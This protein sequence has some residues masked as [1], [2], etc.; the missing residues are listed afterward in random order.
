MKNNKFKLIAFL[1]AMI[2]VATTAYG[3]GKNA[4]ESTTNK[5][6]MAITA[7][8]AQQSALEFELI[9]EQHISRY[10]VIWFWREK[11]TDT[12]YIE[13]Y[14]KEQDG[15]GIGLIQMMDPETGK[16]LT[17]TQWYYNYRQ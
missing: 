1:L 7:S 5:P 11:S 2:C 6:S 8:A 3:C 13:K 15:A 16:P 12:M 14:K 9:F 10:N 17:Y 4:T